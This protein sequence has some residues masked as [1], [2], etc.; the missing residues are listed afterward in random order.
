MVVEDRKPVCGKNVGL[1]H[2]IV[3]D[4]GV[5]VIAPNRT[6]VVCKLRLGPMDEIRRGSDLHD[7]ALSVQAGDPTLHGRQNGLAGHDVQFFRD[8]VYHPGMPGIGQ[9]RRF[10]SQVSRLAKGAV[11]V[12]HKISH[13]AVGTLAA[14]GDVSIAALPNL[15][16]RLPAK[17]HGQDVVQQINILALRLDEHTEVTGAKPDPVSLLADHIPGAGVIAMGKGHLLGRQHPPIEDP[18]LTLIVGV[19]QTHMAE[20]RVESWGFTG[21]EG[22][23]GAALAVPAGLIVEPAEKP[24]GIGAIYFTQALIMSRISSIFF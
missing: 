13:G 23:V 9:D 18:V 5:V 20:I 8:T 3:R 6:V 1:V 16:R 17:V 12:L 15:L 21:S 11:I 10:L 2:R 7:L 24:M 4:D 22:I 14:A 19:H